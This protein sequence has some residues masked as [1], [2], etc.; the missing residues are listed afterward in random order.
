M[1]AACGGKSKKSTAVSDT[2]AVNDSVPAEELRDTMPK[3]MFLLGVGNYLQMLY[4]SYI[5]KPVNDGQDDEYFA[6]SLASWE[7]Q[8]QFRR[9]RADYT[10]YLV[11][12]RIVKLKYVDEV[13]TDPDGNPPS[14]GE[15]HGRDEIPSLGARF[16]VANIKDKKFMNGG[17]VAFTDGYLESHKLLEVKSKSGKLPAAVV[18]QLEEK[19]GMKAARSVLAYEIGG[20]YTFGALQFKGEYKA[21]PKDKYDPDRKYALALDVLIDGDNVYVNEVLGAYFGNGE[22]TWNV[23][24]D[25]EYITCDLAAA[26][27]GGNGIELYYRRYAPESA[28]FGMMYVQDGKLVQRQYEIYHVLIDEDYPIWKSDIMKCMPSMKKQLAPKVDKK[29]QEVS[30]DEYALLHIDYD[31]HREVYLRNSKSG[32]GAIFAIANGEPE[33]LAYSYGSLSIALFNQGVGVKGGCGTGCNFCEYNI[34]QESR[35]V[36]SFRIIGQ[37]DSEGNYKKTA[38]TSDGK[39]LSEEEVVKLLEKI[40][41][42]ETIE[43]K[44]LE[45]QPLK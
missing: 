33:L 2:S 37:T 6:I 16:T 43:E 17:N 4:W 41:N 30:F 20:R 19:Y 18:K 25:G 26:F 21:A 9:N 3:P 36:T 45:W 35:I 12:G 10:N 11:D 13:L 23:D 44:Y 1:L 38:V 29:P 14:V 22:C 32:Y 24:D 31:G 28:A 8:E 15:L 40:G 7:L 42:E 34:V 39:T 27:E 5:E